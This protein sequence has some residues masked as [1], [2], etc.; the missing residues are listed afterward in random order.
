MDFF[1][2]LA[3][4]PLAPAAHGTT[5]SAGGVEGIISTTFLEHG[6]LGVTVMALAWVI[7]KLWQKNQELSDRLLKLADDR[8]GDAKTLIGEYKDTLAEA[9]RTVESLS[10]AIE[11]REKEKRD[12]K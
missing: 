8:L 3:Q 7:V 5:T 6:L 2:L 9:T 4:A 10:D 1:S 11:R 12:D